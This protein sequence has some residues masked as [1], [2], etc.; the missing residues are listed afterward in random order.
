MAEEP[1]NPQSPGQ[2][3]QEEWLR[4]APFDFLGMPVY[5]SQ[6]APSSNDALIRHG[7]EFIWRSDSNLC[8]V[9]GETHGIDLFE[10]I[11]GLQAQVRT[12][13]RMV[14]EALADRSTEIRTLEEAL[15][16]DARKQKNAAT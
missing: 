1:K 10:Q 13:L 3:T 9:C 11:A 14:R 4:G 7:H 16:Y 6:P 5:A 8:S 15:D 2:P 12:L